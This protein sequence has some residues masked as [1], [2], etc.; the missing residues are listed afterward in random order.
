[1]IR[2]GICL[3]S[4]CG[5]ALLGACGSSKENTKVEKETVVQPTASPT[6]APTATATPE[7]K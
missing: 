7:S 2:Y 4:L 6:A 5:L 1:M 3:A